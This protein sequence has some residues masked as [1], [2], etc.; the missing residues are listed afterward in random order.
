MKNWLQTSQWRQITGDFLASLSFV[1]LC[2]LRVWL[3]LE[4]PGEWYVYKNPP[5]LVG[6]GVLFLTIVI[7]ALGVWGAAFAVRQIRWPRVQFLCLIAGGALLWVPADFVSR[8]L[9]QRLLYLLHRPLTRLTF[10]SFA[11]AFGVLVLVAAIWWSRVALGV[12]RGVLLALSPLVVL[13]AIDTSWQVLR[14]QQVFAAFPHEGPALVAHAPGPRVLWLIFDEFDQG[15]AFA[16]RPKG[17][18]L[19]DLDRL[20]SEFLYATRAV[21]PSGNTSTSIPS[22]I[23][24]QV[25]IEANPMGGQDLE[26]T[27]QRGKTESWI[28]MP[29]IFGAVHQRGL[30]SAIVGWYHPYG[31]LFTHSVAD[32]SWRECAGA[33]PT[34]LLENYTQRRGLWRGVLDLLQRQ[35]LTELPFLYRYPSFHFNAGTAGDWNVYRQHQEADYLAIRTKAFALASDPRFD[36]VYVHWP[37]PHPL[38]IYD[39]AQGEV[40]AQT[41]ENYLNNLKLVDV[42]LRDLRSSMKS[43][44]MWDKTSVLISSDHPLRAFWKD[45]VPWQP[46]ELAVVDQA[47]SSNVPFLLK[48]AGQETGIT[49]DGRINTVLTHDLILK[50]LD[51]SVRTAANVTSFLDFHKDSEVNNT[52]GA[53]IR[54]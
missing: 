3:A 53:E 14:A 33:T 2:F 37:V 4:S 43:S 19:P 16:N 40:S 23:A 51:G 35:A 28:T 15:L 46:E 17:L 27:D 12:I 48:M 36:L 5:T 7:A 10:V 50:I 41:R 49:Y 8:T 21:P 11:L 1:N 34:L 52:A 30:N 6:P 13:C 38:G 42:T 26:V 54:E 32:C 44:G 39:E 24:G 9:Y 29:S 47:R 18:S 22:L 20:R 45:E 25:I 31:R